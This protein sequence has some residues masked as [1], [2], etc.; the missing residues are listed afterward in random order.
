MSENTEL[1]KPTENHRVNS[2]SNTYNLNR[3]SVAPM[4]DGTD[5]VI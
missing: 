2:H 3:F 5:R 4:L 1:N